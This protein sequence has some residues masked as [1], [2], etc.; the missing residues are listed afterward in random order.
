MGQ[1]YAAERPGCGIS[2]GH[3]L[4]HT[5]SRSMAQI[6]ALICPSSTSSAA[7]VILFPASLASSSSGPSRSA[8][9]PSRLLGM[10]AMKVLPAGESKNSALISVRMYPGCMLLTRMPWRAHS[11]ESARVMWS[12]AALLMAYVDRLLTTLS[13]MSEATLMIDPPISAATMRRATACA[14]KKGPRVFTLSTVSYASGVS[15]RALPSIESPALLMST[16]IGP[17]CFSTSDSAP[18][19]APRSVTSRVTACALPPPATI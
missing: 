13:E 16:P 10:F 12:S 7:P 14:M 17:R 8:G 6:L 3:S 5:H 15:S 4:I 11:R 18:S 1:W 2:V 19:I 9:D